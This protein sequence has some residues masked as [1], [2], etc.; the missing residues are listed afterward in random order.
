VPFY[1]LYHVPWFLFGIVGFFLWRNFNGH[2]RHH[3]HQRMGGAP[4]HSSVM[5]H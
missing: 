4:P 2:R 5:D 1:P 3:H